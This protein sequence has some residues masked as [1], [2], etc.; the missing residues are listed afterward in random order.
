[1]AKYIDVSDTIHG[2]HIDS[3]SRKFEWKGL[4]LNPY[5]HE[6]MTLYEGD[7]NSFAEIKKVCSEVDR[8]CKGTEK[9]HAE[10]GDCVEA[11]AISLYIR[12]KRKLRETVKE[13]VSGRHGS[14]FLYPRDYTISTIKTPL[15]NLVKVLEE[16]RK[17][18]IKNNSLEEK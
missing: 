14:R 11:D 9:F 13:G 2:T 17:L 10:L 18:M 4:K 3:H 7:R 12:T 6:L 5:T 16:K 8:I 1:M 15:T